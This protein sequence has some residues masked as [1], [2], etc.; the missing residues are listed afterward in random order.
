[1]YTLHFLLSA[2]HNFNQHSPVSA[3]EKK[4]Y[5]NNKSEEYG[6]YIIKT[7]HTINLKLCINSAF[8]SP[9]CVQT[10]FLLSAIHNFHQHGPFPAREKKA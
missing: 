3:R 2:L 4:S 6:T 10:K 8:L 7:T 9:V 1:M 5:V